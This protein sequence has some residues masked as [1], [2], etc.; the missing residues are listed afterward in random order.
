[1]KNLI[2]IFFSL[3]IFAQS[4]SFDS[5]FGVAGKVTYCFNPGSSYVNVDA[6]FQTSGKIVTYNDNYSIVGASLIRWNSNGTLDTTFGVNGFVNFIQSGPFINGGQAARQ[7]IIQPDDKII[8]MGSQQNNTYPNGYWIARLLPNGALDATFSGTGY[9]DLSFGTLQDRGRCIALQP[10]GKILIGGTSGNAAEFFTVARLNSNGSLDTAF[11][12]NGVVQTA[13]S[14]LQSFAE[15]IAVQ[16]DGKIVV[17]GSTADP[18]RANEFALIRY[19]SNGSIDTTFGTNGKV[20]SSISPYSDVIGDIVIEPSGKILTAGVYSSESSPRMCMV[21][22]LANGSMDTTFGQNG[23][24]IHPDYFTKYCNIARQ[25]DGRI[26]LAGGF[27]GV[28]FLTTRYNANGTKDLSFGI[29]GEVNL[30]PT[31]YGYTAKVLLQPDN[32]IVVTGITTAINNEGNQ[33]ICPTVI[34]L[35]PGTLDVTNNA[36]AS[37]VVYPNPSNGIFQLSFTSL[38]PQE[39]V[40][41][42]YDIVGKKLI[43]KKVLITD[44]TIEINFFDYPAGVY[45][46]RIS[47]GEMTLNKKLVK[48]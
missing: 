33:S 43:E 25:I 29:N 31:L 38:T 16:P 17:G 7:M 12:T 46:L 10:D 45:H 22:Y 20:I 6:G 18:L 32:K 4:G 21:R 11:G 19:Q 26:L 48:K 47:A 14:S 3:S 34:R 15:K 41:V 35:N 40:Y 37:V 27:T 42:V 23:L 9:R 13:F 39:A 5:S 1:M 44:N 8:I 24:V 36:V 2:C 30:F 28:Y